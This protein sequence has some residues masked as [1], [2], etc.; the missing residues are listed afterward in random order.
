[1]N[2]LQLQKLILLPDESVQIPDIE[3]EPAS[4]TSLFFTGERELRTHLVIPD[5]IVR[6]F[7][8]GT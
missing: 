1:M 2:L 7:A 5:W 8:I 6:V 4:K 3:E